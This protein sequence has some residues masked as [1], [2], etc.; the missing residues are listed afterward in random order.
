M[1]WLSSPISL[2][3]ASTRI[4]GTASPGINLRGTGI[5][6]CTISYV[7]II[8]ILICCL[9]SMRAQ[10]C[11]TGPDTF[12]FVRVP[13]ELGFTASKLPFKDREPSI[14]MR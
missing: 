6:L 11:F 8:S 1:F 9:S 14:L 7:S 4:G 5:A 2:I 13:S 3:V 12:F 10:S